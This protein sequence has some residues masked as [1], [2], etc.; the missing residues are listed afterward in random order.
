MTIQKEFLTVRLG[1]VSPHQAPL[2]ARRIKKQENVK[3]LCKLAAL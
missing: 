2:Q 1:L 3:R